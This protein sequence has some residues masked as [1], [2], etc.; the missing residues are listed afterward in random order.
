MKIGILGPGAIG[1]LVGSLLYKVGNNVIF[2]GKDSTVEFIKQNGI[3]IKSIFYS[4]FNFFPNAIINS[5]ETFDLIFIT[6]KSFELK[7]AL[8][9]ISQNINDSTII[10]SLLNGVGH[11][12]IISDLNVKNLIIGTIGAVEVKLNENRDVIHSSTGKTHIE[13]SSNNDFSE[14]IISLLSDLMI[15][16]GFSVNIL[17]NE[18]EVIWRKLVRLAAISTM[19]SIAKAPLG[20]VLNN[21]ELNLMMENVV[22][23]L[24]LIA[25]TQRFWVKPEEVMSQINALPE[26]LTTSMQRDIQSGKQSEIEAIL[27]GTI[28]IGKAEGLSLPFLE[29]CYNI[30]IKNVIS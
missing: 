6:V 11:K 16:A 20:N 28:R 2:I 5:V 14:S 10:I 27:G 8:K 25:E 29:N 13:M 12:E 24:C 17:N 23:E 19:T 21:P 22:Q 15:E 9:S 4:D 26:S 18:N 7:K 3:K 1:C 30:L